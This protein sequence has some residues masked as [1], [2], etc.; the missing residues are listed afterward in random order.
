MIFLGEGELHPRCPGGLTCPLLTVCTCNKVATVRICSGRSVPQRG[1]ARGSPLPQGGL[2]HPPTPLN[3]QGGASPEPPR[4]GPG[5]VGCPRGSLLAEGPCAVSVCPLHPLPPRGAL[6]LHSSCSAASSPP[7]EGSPNP[8]AEPARLSPDPPDPPSVVFRAGAPPFAGCLCKPLP[9]GV[10]V[11]PPPFP[12]SGL[13]AL[14]CPPWA[15]ASLPPLGAG[16]PGA[17]APARGG[18]SDALFSL[19]ALLGDRGHGQQL[20]GPR[21]PPPRHPSAAP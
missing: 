4:R 6:S 14:P 2:P 7:S 11:R 20:G 19:Q 3:L 18:P 8:R 9:R 10:P 1:P 21:T 16:G 12:S 17:A 15:R 13:P 5:R